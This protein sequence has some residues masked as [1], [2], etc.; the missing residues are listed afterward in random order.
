MSGAWPM[1]GLFYAF[2]ALLTCLWVARAIRR[3][4]E[5][6][7]RHELAAAR[8]GWP[9]IAAATAIGWPAIA[10]RVAVYG[11]PHDEES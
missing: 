7:R 4:P 10:I 5:L 1:F 3:N 8:F 11:E 6:R 2:G 9:V